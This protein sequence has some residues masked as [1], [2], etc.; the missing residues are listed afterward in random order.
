MKFLIIPF[1]LCL[2]LINN[3]APDFHVIYISRI[4]MD[5]SLD[6]SR[7][8]SLNI[9]KSQTRTLQS[10]HLEDKSFDD[11]DDYDDDDY[12]DLSLF[13]NSSSAPL[14]KS[15]FSAVSGELFS[16]QEERANCTY[17]NS[18]KEDWIIDFTGVV[19]DANK[20]FHFY[21]NGS[22][23]GKSKTHQHGSYSTGKYT[24][25]DRNDEVYVQF[26]ICEN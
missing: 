20:Y 2:F 12:D 10:V 16:L 21:F 3:C 8:K 13:D 9:A 14:R 24:L 4:D 23:L 25:I 5:N 7:E 26:T 6:L 15:Y 22:Y 11:D 17:H 1:L 19:P 18:F